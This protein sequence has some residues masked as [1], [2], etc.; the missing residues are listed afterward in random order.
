MRA[1]LKHPVEI[2]ADAILSALIL[3]PLLGSSLLGAFWYNFF[4][5]TGEY[6]YHANVRTPPWL[7]YFIQTGSEQKLLAMLAFR[8]VYV[9]DQPVQNAN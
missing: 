9:E 1:I 4:A 2:L 3:Y 5:G 7:R 6:F 8:D